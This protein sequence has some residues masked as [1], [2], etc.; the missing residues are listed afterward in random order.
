MLKVHAQIEGGNVWA[1]PVED[2]EVVFMPHPHGGPETLWFNFMIENASAANA[3]KPLTL[4]LLNVNNILGGWQPANLRPVMA[5]DGGA[6]ARLP[7]PE[8]DTRPD[9]V[10]HARWRVKVPAKSLQVAVCYPYG[11]EELAQL[12]E[13]LDWQVSVVGL[14][15]A[16]RPMLRLCNRTGAKGEVAPAI[17]CVAR[18]H[19]G[20]TPGSWVLD[21]FLR[22]LHEMGP[23]AP[24][25]WAV[26]LSNIDGVVSGDYGKDNFPYDLNRAWGLPPMRHETHCLRIDIQRWKQRCRT[27]VIADF[28]APGACE[29]EGLYTFVADPEQAPERHAV[30][31][32][33]AEAVQRHLGD[34][35]AKEFSRVGNYPSRWNTPTLTCFGWDEHRLPA[36]TFEVPYG[37]IGDEPL[38]IER[39]RE[40]GRRMAD[41]ICEALLTLKP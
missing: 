14:S 20:E 9:G 29:A 4:T 31:V 15:Q 21:G 36:L 16:G 11:Q 22:R 18:Q 33:F 32:P 28:H 27:G 39:Y 30:N 19:S 37:V 35:A 12:A 24:M 17:Y 5:V 6:F 26:P 38:T 34:M 41:G 3:G 13:V 40:A 7:S 1:P 8:I 2:D 10:V 23:D 25:C